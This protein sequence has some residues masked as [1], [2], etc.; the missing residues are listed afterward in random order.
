MEQ[1]INRVIR[2]W[3]RRTGLEARICEVDMEQQKYGWQGG[4]GH[5]SR[6]HRYVFFFITLVHIFKE[7]VILSRIVLYSFGIWDPQEQSG[8]P[9]YLYVIIYQLC[10]FQ[11]PGMYLMKS[12]WLGF[13][14]YLILIYLLLFPEFFDW[15]CPSING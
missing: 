4:R 7:V 6:A 12:V 15:S 2:S 10:K 3:R 5:W 14:N 13:Y 9:H 1:Q 8:F 11:A